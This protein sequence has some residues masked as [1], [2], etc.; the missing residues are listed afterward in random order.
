MMADTVD[1]L[2]LVDVVDAVDPV[3]HLLLLKDVD[4]SVDVEKE[5]VMI[6]SDG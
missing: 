2:V 4:D 6:D 1:L 5:G 3:V